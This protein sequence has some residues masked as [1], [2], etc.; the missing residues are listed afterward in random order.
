MDIKF[1]IGARI[2][3][4]RLKN[5]LTQEGLAFKA[6]MDK[7]YLNEVENGK[8]NV[9]VVNLSKIILALDTSIAFF[10]NHKLFKK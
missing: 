6:D 7:T 4:L 1:R 2:K 5:N 10:F 3:E 9:S 8:R